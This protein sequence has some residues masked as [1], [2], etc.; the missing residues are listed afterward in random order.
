MRANPLS[1][2]VFGLL[3][4]CFLPFAVGAELNLQGEWIQGGTIRGSV[5]P[6]TSLFYRTGSKK[7]A[8]PITEKGYFL[9]GLG[10]K[11]AKQ[12]TLEVIQQGQSEQHKFTVKQRVYQV[13][14][15][16]GLKKSQVELSEKDLKRIRAEGK[17]IRQA[18]EAMH[19]SDE[20]HKPFIWPSH[21]RISGVYGSARILNGKPRQPHYGID[22]AAPVGTEVI[23]PAG[24]L[25]T[26]AED[27]TFFSGQLLVIAHGNGLTSSFLHLSKILVKK[28]QY[29][30]QGQ[31]IAEIGATG[32]VTGPHLDWR[33]NWFDIRVDPY[34]LLDPAVRDHNKP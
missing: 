8:V 6:G 18:R 28:G 14:R 34:Y 15:I 22:I 23:A 2:A 32:R 7:Y 10:R 1:K 16:N 31:R 5:P 19:N 12:V 27:D 26:L 30:E 4:L 13:Q 25:V 24:G 33:A 17:K 3:L 11:A 29:V 21:G 9:I 20:F